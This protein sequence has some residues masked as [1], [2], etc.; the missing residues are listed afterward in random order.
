MASEPTLV[1]TKA[2]RRAAEN[3]TD[4]LPRPCATTNLAASCFIN[5]TFLAV[6][7]LTPLRQHL[8]GFWHDQDNETFAQLLRVAQNSINSAESPALVRTVGSSAERLAAT[9]LAFLTPP[10]TA[11]VPLLLT[12][13]YYHGVQED[14]E[15][16]LRRMLFAE[17]HETEL[18]HLSYSIRQEFLV[19]RN[20]AA[21]QE[22]GHPTPV[23]VLQ[24][25]LRPQGRLCTS[26]ADA[27]TA[28]LQPEEV[29]DDLQSWRGGCPTCSNNERPTRGSMYYQAPDALLIQLKRWTSH[30]A[31]DALLHQ[32]HPDSTITFADR[33]YHL[34]SVVSH[35]GQSVHHGHYTAT[36]K[37]PTPEG[38]WWHYNDDR[39]SRTSSPAVYRRSEEHIY[40]AFY[41]K[42][43]WGQS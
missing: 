9:L 11:R 18:Q 38:D 29:F 19:C 43:T 41:E 17:D 34:V 13:R 37:Y 7:A 32:V 39:S 28:H 14:A 3:D 35:I 36:I 20:C 6:L 25:E 40:L 21:R 24:L 22:L 4:L 31:E 33:T 30:R 1:Q 16:F 27:L 42:S 5:A 12:D 15:E 2:A 8:Q 10:M 23:D 26:I